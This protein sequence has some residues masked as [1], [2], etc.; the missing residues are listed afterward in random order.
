MQHRDLNS[1]TL[2]AV[3]Q[4]LGYLN[5]SSGATD[6]NFLRNIDRIY[7][8]MI[9]RRCDDPPNGDSHQER[10]D[11]VA[12]ENPNWKATIELLQEQLSR[13]ANDNATFSNADQ[14]TAVLK[15][16]A[17]QVIPGYR[18]FHRD[19]L[20]HQ[21]DDELFG[22]FMLARIFETL[23]QQP[24]PWEKPARVAD[25]A[26]SDLN[27]FLGHRPI[28]TLESQKI[29]PRAHEW[30]RPIPLYVENAGVA[31]GP[32]EELITQTIEMLHCIDD[33]LAAAAY[34]D[35]QALEELA[36]DPRAYDFDHPVN[37]RPSYHFGEWDPQHIDNKGR[38][39]RFIVRE[40]NLQALL[41]RVNDLCDSPELGDLCP[42]REE[43]IWE[44]AVVLAG[45]ILMASGV[46]GSGPDTHDSNTTLSTIVTRFA[47]HRDSFYEHVLGSVDGPRG[48]R[49]RREAEKLHQ[50]FGG[51]RQ[52]LN[53]ALS[54]RRARQ[55]EHVKLAKV[56]AG[57]GY[58]DAAQR[59]VDA[60]PV[61]SAR[62]MCR[63]DC[64]L[65]AG[66]QALNRNDRQTTLSELDQVVDLLHRG[67]ACGAIVD[68]WNILGFD[69]NFSLFPALENSV[70]DHRIDDLVIKVERIGDLFARTW[71]DAAAADDLDLASRIE[72][73]YE[74]F[75]EWWHKFAAHTVEN[76]QAK[77]ARPEFDA[78]R[79]VATALNSWHRGG[80]A[81]GDVKFWAPFVEGFD[82]PKAYA[83]VIETLLGNNDFVSS[84]SLLIHWISQNEKV[85]FGKG[86]GS[87]HRIANR[88]VRS[89]T[90]SGFRHK[91]TNENLP[92]M[93]TREAWT[94]LRRFFDFLEANAEELWQPPKFQLA[95]EQRKPKER[96]TAGDVG[97]IDE[98]E[99]ENLF[100]AAYE[101]VVY[102]D[103]TDDGN[104][105]EV[106]ENGPRTDQ[107]LRAE[108]QRILNR[109]KFLS[110]V[111]EM[112]T[113]TS[114]AAGSVGLD[115]LAEDT[116]RTRA[117]IEGWWKQS[118]R[119]RRKLMQLIDDVSGESIPQP[120]GHQESM[121]DYDR[122]R[123]VIASLVEHAIVSTVEMSQA[124]RFLLAVVQI[125]SETGEAPAAPEPTAKNEG[126]IE[127]ELRE[128]AR[129]IVAALQRDRETAAA[130]G[131]EM[132]QQLPDKQIL[133]VPQS[134][135]G[136]GKSIAIVRMRQRIIQ[137]S[138]I[139]LP[140]LGLLATTQ[141][142][143][144]TARKMELNELEGRAAVTQFDE[145]FEVGFRELVGCCVRGT[146][147]DKGAGNEYDADQELISC[148]EQLTEAILRTWLEHSY[149]LRLSALEGVMD[150]K[151]WQSLVEFI[152]QYGGDLFTQRFLNIGNLKAILHCGVGNWLTQLE[153]SGIEAPFRLLEELDQSVPRKE[154]I[155]KL[156]M[157]FT[158]VV[159]NFYEYQDYNL[160]TTQSDQGDKLYTL[161]DFLRLR[162]SYDRIAWNLKPV[163]IAHE[164][165]VRGGRNEAAQLWRRALA[166]RVGGEATTYLN[167]L[168]GMQDKYAMRMASVANRI[169]E[170]FIRPMA[171]DRMRASVAPAIRQLGDSGPRHAFEL[172]EE[173]TAMMM[174]EPAGSGFGSP[175]WLKALEQEIDRIRPWSA[176]STEDL[177]EEQLLEPYDLSLEE[178]QEQ[179]DAL[180]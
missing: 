68:P 18:T 121:I 20:F 28:P 139:V 111:A 123:Q 135:G 161:L 157:I 63:I 9:S 149:T 15:L 98:D 44:A 72:S 57:M 167:R 99:S 144:N 97:E 127:E 122:Y 81:T 40:V 138:L 46:S 124:E 129:M 147:S 77:S 148:L 22:S 153:E 70:R 4:V 54:Q 11:G 164:I 38:Y 26:V 180:I 85:G 119:N 49:L 83:L 12:D 84:M 36:V 91:T 76:M 168:A 126:T 132:L 29:E 107:E 100:G 10:E 23:L 159:E 110:S 150:D 133:Y 116:G 48:D 61:A 130:V 43:L 17:D 80:A 53:M 31:V 79:Q 115:Q 32:Y 88:W 160:T 146:E 58:V 19:L 13:L 95:N 82:T 50:P 106:F 125:H 41:Q 16:V 105:G 145:L 59:Q 103:S 102:K 165:I 101:D 33:D 114:I 104:D 120:A 42:S 170:R 14:A 24:K 143:I 175:A 155:N 137:N 166:E 178:L 75:T 163:V 128:S 62:M 177:E 56:F 1:E 174:R 25:Q 90:G 6:P 162:A 134:R 141:Q 30:V 87:F 151:R 8:D 169:G 156:T 108:S 78:A 109:L 51:A 176:S 92:R 37:R 140:R 142:L 64:A 117:T 55:L 112:W 27:C 73:R 172:L 86:T 154:A 35:P 118:H 45:T 89:V 131:V 96:P 21:S 158:A 173:E 74:E 47:A 60:V 3:E 152:E 5:F 34:F 71:S 52:N 69:G 65:T 94:L 171:I 179:L 93:E 136:D 66:R 67:I 7:R 39:R 113:T 2:T